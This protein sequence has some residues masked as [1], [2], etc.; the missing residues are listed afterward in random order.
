ME[1]GGKRFSLKSLRAIAL[2]LLIGSFSLQAQTPADSVFMARIVAEAL[3]NGHA[4]KQLGALCKEVG[5]RLSGSDNA[6]KGVQWAQQMLSSYG[7]DSVYTQPVMVPRWER[8]TEDR[9]TLLSTNLSELY[10]FLPEYDYN[11]ETYNEAH[12]KPNP[13]GIYGLECTALGGS[14]GGSVLGPLVVVNSER[15]LDSVGGLGQLLGRVVLL[16]RPFEKDFVNTFAAYSS[17]VTQRV[18]GA[19]QCAKYGAI[20]VLV[21]SMSHRCDLHAHTGVTHYQAGI[22][23]I[24]IAAVATG[25]ADLLEWLYRQQWVP[26][27]IELQL[28]CQ[29]LP[30]R[31]SAN[32][33]AET[34][35]R[36]FP[37]KIIAFGGHFDSWDEGEGAHDDGAGCMHTFEALRLLKTLGY[38][39]RHTL[40]CVWWINEENGLKGALKYAEL[41]AAEGEQHIAAL[42][43]DRGG[44]VPR[45][46]G[47]DSSLLALIQ[48]YQ[49]WLAA[50]GFGELTQG[51]G[52]A[53]VGPLKRQD[54]S[55]GLVGF[56]P[57]SQRYFDVHHAETDVFENVNRRELE[58]GAAA[59]A[60]MIYLL[61]Q[62]LD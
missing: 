56:I 55:V 26:A 29:T 30:D 49:P 17:C 9:V 58:L 6:E 35:G 33:I 5:P 19:P 34:R 52:G 21:R 16:N 46:F 38:Q 59:V 62:Q 25:V 44:F 53:D 20:G 8:G 47:L 41:C 36:E 57:D 2:C 31:M 51:G 24:P 54:P 22:D 18:N 60:C 37:N 13:L 4:Y 48:P 7:F 45:G 61:D 28:G 32:S 27:Q 40:R 12:P 39:P 50:Y 1:F 15:E 10:K 11:C 43:S 42:E 3:N 14:V 23:S